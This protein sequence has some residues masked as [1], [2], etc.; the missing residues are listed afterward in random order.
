M[1]GCVC[2]GLH[3]WRSQAFACCPA[4][5]PPSP[6]QPHLLAQT[7]PFL[8]HSLFPGPLFCPAQAAQ[9]PRVDVLPAAQDAAHHGGVPAAPQPQP[10]HDQAANR[11]RP[12]QPTGRQQS[13]LAAPVGPLGASGPSGALSAA[14]PTWATLP[15]R[16]K[17]YLGNP[18]CPLQALPGQPCLPTASPTWATLPAAAWRASLHPCV[19]A[20]GPG[21]QA[22]PP[23]PCRGL[24]ADHDTNGHIDNF[25][26]F[27]RPGVVLLAWTDDE[28][29]P[30]VRPG[31]RDRPAWDPG[32]SPGPRGGVRLHD[33]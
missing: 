24:F 27:A 10:P 18:A 21:H 14:S 31:P 2:G 20:P 4:A 7:L 12:V 1:R 26:C 33:A 19:P 11:S 17:P 5:P 8:G 3:A 22:A 30:Q 15:A 13:G 9:Q 32:A 29:D 16:C 6:P 23:P 28:S 25:A